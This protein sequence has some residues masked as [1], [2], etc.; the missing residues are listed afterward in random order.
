MI[1]TCSRGFTVYERLF[2]LFLFFTK[3]YLVDE[4]ILMNTH[5][6]CFTAKVTKLC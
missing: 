4:V 1:I 2:F 3:I 6:T 5:M